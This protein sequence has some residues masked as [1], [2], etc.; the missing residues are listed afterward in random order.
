ML[1]PRQEKVQNK[2]EHLHTRNKE[3][4]KHYQR[5]WDLCQNDSGANLNRLP[6]V[7]AG[8]ISASM[9]TIPWIKN[10]SKCLNS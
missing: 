10:T 9:G 7:K 1:S 6:L 8:A 5:L 2:P 4:I 3:S